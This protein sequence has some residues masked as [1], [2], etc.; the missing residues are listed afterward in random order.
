M[1]RYIPAGALALGLVWGGAALA[2]NSEVDPCD[3]RLMSGDAEDV[4]I[5]QVPLGTIDDV[6]LDL[7]EVE[8]ASVSEVTVIETRE[9]RGGVRKGGYVMLGGGVDGYTGDL[10][11]D[12]NVGPSWGATVGVTGTIIGVEAGYSGAANEID[13]RFGT[14]LG[15][16]VDVVRQGGQAA[17]KINLSPTA[18][19]PYLLGGIGLEHRN[20]RNGEALGFESGTNGYVPAAAGL[21]WNIGA[22]TADLRFSYNF[23]FEDDFAPGDPTGDRYQGTLMLGGTL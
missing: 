6:T 22:F 7:E 3:P 8:D 23:M 21:R 18:L 13:N 15:S 14:D 17:L 10:N 11:H 1:R 2:Q 12:F 16:G 5:R 4:S 9:E 19:H 20:F